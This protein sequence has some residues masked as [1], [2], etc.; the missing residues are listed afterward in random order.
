M[1]QINWERVG[2]ALDILRE[3]LK[4]FIKQKMQ[5]T[6]GQRW[7]QEANVSLRDHHLTSTPAGEL[8]A[9]TQ[10]LLQ[11]LWDRPGLFNLGDTEKTLVRELRQTR[12]DWAH[13][14]EFSDKDALRAHDNI[15]LL[16]I[17][18]SAS[19]QASEVERQKN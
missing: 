19:S 12:R 1:A 13:Q 11:I 6:F 14:K 10:A 7:L 2:R 8:T 17:F 5:A 18:A 9:D 15:Q 4:P 16:L 3:G